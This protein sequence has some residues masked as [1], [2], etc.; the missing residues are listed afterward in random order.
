M[1]EI[2]LDDIIKRDRHI[3]RGSSRSVK[4]KSV[5]EKDSLR[6]VL[7][8]TAKTVFLIES[9]VLVN[10][11]RVIERGK[12]IGG[13]APEMIFKRYRLSAE[14]LSPLVDVVDV[15]AKV[16]WELVFVSLVFAHRGFCLGT[17]ALKN[18]RNDNA[19]ALL[20]TI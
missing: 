1:G 10:S 13:G 8:R 19:L 4:R 11:S 14:V 15:L 3:I 12:I 7:K 9:C 16:A 17:S 2:V 20:K 18:L 5:R 6:A